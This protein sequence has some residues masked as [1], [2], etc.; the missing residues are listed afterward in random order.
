MEVKFSLDIGMC[1]KA[2]ADTGKFGKTPEEVV[3][4]LIQ[5]KVFLLDDVKRFTIAGLIHLGYDNETIKRIVPGTPYKNDQALKGVKKD[6]NSY[7][8]GSLPE[9]GEVSEQKEPE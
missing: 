6:W 7:F 2:L 5:Y 8:E 3:K 9:S 4:H 1:L